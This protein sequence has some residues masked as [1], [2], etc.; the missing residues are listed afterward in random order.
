MTD[1]YTLDEGLMPK[2]PEGQARVRVAIKLLNEAYRAGDEQPEDAVRLL[3]LAICL[4]AVAEKVSAE[5]AALHFANFVCDFPWGHV[6]AVE[7]T[8]H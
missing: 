3:S 4:C 5:D 8:L 7:R 2:S 6:G 1:R